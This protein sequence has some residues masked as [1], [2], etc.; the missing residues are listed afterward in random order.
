M[1]DKESDISGK[2]GIYRGDFEDFA[3]ADVAWFSG[4]EFDSLTHTAIGT[5]RC[6]EGLW[7]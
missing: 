2:L 3:Q 4:R 6:G 1:A 7:F 5:P